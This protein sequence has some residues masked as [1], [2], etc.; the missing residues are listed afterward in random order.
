M[1]ITSKILL[2]AIVAGGL[3]L[4]F[5]TTSNLAVA[6]ESKQESKQVKA[7]PAAKIGSLAPTFTLTDTD[8]KTHDLAALTK[9]G[10]IVVIEWFNPDCPFVKKHH[11]VNTTFADLF[12]NYSGKGVVFLAINSGAEGKQGFGKDLNAK[13]AKEWGMQYPVLLDADGKVG[14]AYGAKTTPHMY[15][16]GK[17]GKVAYMGAID[18]QKEGGKNYVRQALDQIIKG[19]TVTEAST[20]P[21]GC[22]VKYGA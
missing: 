10:K 13:T 12:K 20:K 14:K 5:P 22:S 6:Q 17:D 2:A 9:E 15:I 19:E 1:K 11:E 21:Y 8:G 4:A 7:E 3:A 18:D 16:I